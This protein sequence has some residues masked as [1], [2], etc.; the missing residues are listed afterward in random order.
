[1]VSATPKCV[2]V[3]PENMIMHVQEHH[4]HACG[5]HFWGGWSHCREN[6]LSAAEPIFLHAA[7]IADDD[8]MWSWRAIIS[9]QCSQFSA[10]VGMSTSASRTIQ[11]LRRAKLKKPHVSFYFCIPRLL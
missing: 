10:R 3:A 6:P 7:C 4:A 11:R 5:V 1:M 9:T 2:S 8:N